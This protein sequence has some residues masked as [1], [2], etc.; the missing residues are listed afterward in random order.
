M[1]SAVRM[2]TTFL[3]CFVMS[4]MAGLLFAS[5]SALERPSLK[6][7]LEGQNWDSIQD[8]QQK[9]EQAES[10]ASFG[11]WEAAYRM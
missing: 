6:R 8:W 7:I 1:T 9:E 10:M 3:A 11:D 5:P 4:G 2:L